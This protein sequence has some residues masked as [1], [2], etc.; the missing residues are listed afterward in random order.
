MPIIPALNSARATGSLNQRRKQLKKNG[1]LLFLGG[2]H[3]SLPD[4]MIDA[5]KSFFCVSGTGI[6]SKKENGI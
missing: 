5:K 3:E 4:L 1:N 2:M 6:A